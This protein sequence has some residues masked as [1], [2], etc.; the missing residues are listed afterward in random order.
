MYKKKIAVQCNILYSPLLQHTQNNEN[1]KSYKNFNS[2]YVN[3]VLCY[4]YQHQSDEVKCALFQS[5]CTNMYC[6]QLCFNSTKN[7]LMKLFPSYNSVTRCRLCISNKF[8]V[9]T[10]LSL[11]SEMK[12]S[13]SYFFLFI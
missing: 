2:I 10:L 9:L 12:H 4:W 6:C 5:Y 7:S 3:K 8:I 1:R 13:Y 11:F